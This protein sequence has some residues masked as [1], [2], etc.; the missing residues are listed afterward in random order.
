MLCAHRRDAGMATPK[1]T[2][3]GRGYMSTLNYW[4]H[5]NE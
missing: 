3:L 4:S 5:K 2:P 1:H